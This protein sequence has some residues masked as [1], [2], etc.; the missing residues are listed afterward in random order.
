MAAHADRILEIHDGHLG[1]RHG[2]HTTGAE[3]V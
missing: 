2:R 1:R 3:P